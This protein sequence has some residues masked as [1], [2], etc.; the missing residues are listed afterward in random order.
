[1]SEISMNGMLNNKQPINLTYSLSFLH[2]QYTQYAI[3]SIQR[4]LFN[5]LYFEYRTQIKFSTQKEK[6]I[7][8][9]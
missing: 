6:L 4:I 1:M 8:M 5:F 2:K 3:H 9:N 7:K